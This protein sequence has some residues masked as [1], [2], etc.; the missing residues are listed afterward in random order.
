MQQNQ[1]KDMT[2]F[3]EGQGLWWWAQCQRRHLDLFLLRHHHIPVLH[4]V[5]SFVKNLLCKHRIIKPVM[6]IQPI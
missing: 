5:L 3:S 1:L 4:C 6:K 2:T